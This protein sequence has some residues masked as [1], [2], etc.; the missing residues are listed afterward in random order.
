M[1]T[2]LPS[3]AAAA[4]FVYV[5]TGA[6]YLAEARRSAASVRQL[7]RDAPICLIT[8]Q[9]AA[10]DGVFTI[11]QAPRGPVEH[12]PVDK[13][14]AV[15]A[16]FERCVFLDTDT[17]ARDDLSGLFE[18]L[19][20]FDV[21][22]HQDLKRGW[23]Y[24]LPDVPAVFSEFNTGVLAFRRSPEVEEFFRAWRAEYVNLHAQLGL[25]ND[26]P[27]FRRALYHSRL[28]VAPLPSEYHFLGNSPNSLLWKVRLVHARGDLAAIARTA[29]EQLG[30][31]VYV[32]EVGVITA[33][34]GRR[35]WLRTT[36]HIFWRMLRL[37]VSPPR[38]SA[39][40]N[41]GQWWLE[42]TSRPPP[43]PRPDSHGS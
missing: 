25:V 22:A 18:M 4:G 27:A 5:A 43:P 42:E 37:V 17:L 13:L 26:Q 38:D 33:Y 28:R 20:Q 11:V 41:P 10:P 34:R 9:P 24:V 7:H 40:A 1:T 35:H 8:D 19:D 3:S 21:A 12:K 39:A 32:P 36:L 23:H 29:E 30:D 14:L 6:G 31:R 16:P 15:E 2:N